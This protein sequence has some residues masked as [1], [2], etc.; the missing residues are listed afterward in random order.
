MV[1]QDGK[2]LVLFS[3]GGVAGT[4]AE[5]EFMDELGRSSLKEG[6][7]A[8]C[9]SGVLGQGTQSRSINNDA[10]AR[11]DGTFSHAQNQY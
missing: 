2:H 5:C 1:D 3:S 11:Q 10:M 9:S 7:L 4:K 6:H 8:K